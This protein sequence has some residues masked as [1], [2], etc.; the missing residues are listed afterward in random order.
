MKRIENISNEA[1]KVVTLPIRLSIGI[2]NA[3]L[4]HTPDTLDIPFEIKRKENKDGTKER[5]QE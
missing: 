2:F 5:P 1:L 4:K 3:V